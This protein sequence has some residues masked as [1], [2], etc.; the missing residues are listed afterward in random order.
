ADFSLRPR[1]PHHLRP[2]RGTQR[3]HSRQRGAAAPAAA[4]RAAAECRGPRLGRAARRAR[5]AP[6]G[7]VSRGGAARRVRRAGERPRRDGSAQRDVRAP[8]AR[9]HDGDDRRL[10]QLGPVLSQ[11]VFALEDQA[12]RPRTIRRGRIEARHLRQARHRAR[13]L[14]DPLAHERLHPRVQ[15]S[16]LRR[17]RRRG[18]LP[19]RQRPARHLQRRRVARGGVRGAAPDH[20]SRRRRRGARLRDQMRLLSSLRSRIFLAGALLAV[21]CIA[22]AIALVNVRVTAEAERTLEREML[23]TAAQIDQLRDERSQ[24]FTVMARLI[25]DLPKLKAAIDTND[26]LTVED[27]ARGYRS[28]L[29]ANLLLVTNRRG[30]TLYSTRLAPPPVAVEQ[31][32]IRDALGGRDTSSLLAQPNGILQIVTVPVTLDRPR[33]EILG[34]LSA[35]F[36]LDDAF[37]AQLKK[38]TGSDLAF[39]MDGRILASTLPRDADTVLAAQLRGFRPT[40]LVLGQD[41]YEALPR[42]LTSGATAVAVTAADGQPL[43]AGQAGPVAL[44]LRSRTDQLRSLSSIHTGFAITGVLAVLLAMALSFAVART[45]AQPLANIAD[46]M[47]E[48]SATGDLTRKISRQQASTFNALTDSIARFQREMSQKERLTSLGRLSTVIAHEVRNPLMIIKASLHGLRQPEV[49]PQALREA[50]H[51]IDEEVARLNRIVNEVLDFAR[52]IRFELTPVDV[53]ALCRESVAAAMAS[54]SGPAIDTQLDPAIGTISADHERPR[55]ALVNMLVNA[56]HATNGNGQPVR[57]STR[58]DVDRIQI[59][60]ADCGVGISAEDLGRVFDPYFTTKRGGTGLGLP[61]AK[62][63][64]EGLGGTIAVS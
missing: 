24:N 25:A 62:N 57:L 27:I 15:P 9:D 14:R 3:R 19:H 64:V 37:A 20:R 26:P 41:E 63:I 45:I 12:L 60:I 58:I 42:L 55:I 21:V 54:G 31:P 8:P 56:R 36:L 10:P 17:Q 4:G 5:S 11:R 33:E 30:Q 1:P 23:A 43:H 38:I 39:G 2:S 32:A 61:I 50:V 7:R 29:H 53:N 44:I 35:G 51:D 28:Q 59:A 16:V 22:M 6:F 47:R 49:T 48:M 34:T 18:P 52:P 46:V 13:V 40:R